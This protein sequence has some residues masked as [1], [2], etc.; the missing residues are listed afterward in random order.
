MEESFTIFVGIDWATESHQVCILDA[1][2]V[3]RKE[4]QVS[5]SAEGLAGLAE[6]LN[7]EAAGNPAA[8]AVAI[9]VPR[10]AIVETLLERGMQVFSVNP[11]QL[12]H[13]RDR[14]TMAGAKDDRRDAL[15][16]ADSLRTDARAF[17]KLALDDPLVI[18]IRELSRM[19]EDLREM[20][21]VLTNRL[22]EQVF[23]FAPHLLSLCPSAD[24]GWF[25]EL[26][27]VMKSPKDMHALSLDN[28]AHILK[29]H[30]IRRVNANDVFLGSSSPSKFEDMSI[31]TSR[32]FSP[33][34][35]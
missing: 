24:E 26:L 15:V 32:S 3:V 22:R 10:G 31:A 5:H 19:H 17:R 29:A 6:L 11:K 21:N 30:R 1:Q 14:H 9:E 8:A 18:R 28:V 12:D 25:L 23:R 35:G 34:L 13:F 2:G 7:R 4:T 20:R 33:F 16:L 27:K